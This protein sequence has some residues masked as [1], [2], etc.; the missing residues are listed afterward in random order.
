[1]SESMAVQGR[2]VRWNNSILEGMGREK[3]LEKRDD[4]RERRGEEGGD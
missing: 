4:K 1:M 2:W 3:G